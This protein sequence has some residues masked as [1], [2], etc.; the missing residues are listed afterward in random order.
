[1]VLSPI[2]VRENIVSSRRWVYCEHDTN[3]E[4]KELFK[5][6]PSLEM[7]EELNAKWDN[8]CA[9]IFL[10]PRIIEKPFMVKPHRL[11]LFPPTYEFSFLMVYDTDSSF[12]VHHQET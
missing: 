10:E 9:E 3:E 1:M 2:D 4:L 6:M 11:S 5:D 12:I 8:Q 7:L